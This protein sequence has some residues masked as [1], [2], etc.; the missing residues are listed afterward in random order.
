MAFI[1]IL[2]PVVLA[3][4]MFGVGTSLELSDFKEIVARPKLVALGLSLQMLFLPAV[5]FLVCLLLPVSN[6]WKL[7]IIIL[8]LCPGGATSNF[9]SYLLELKTAL[10]IS[11]TAINSLLILVTIPVGVNLGAE[12]FMHTSASFSLSVTETSLNVLLIVL[13][14]V[15]LGLIFHRQFPVL[16]EH[17]KQPV[18]VV[19][20]LLLAAVFAIKFFGGEESGGSQISWADIAVLAPVMLGF[21]LFTM[22][23]SYWTANRIVK[24]SAYDAI[25]IGIEVGLQNTTLALLVATVMIGDE[26]MAEPTLVYAMFSFFTTLG[27]GYLAKWSADKHAAS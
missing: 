23:M 21:H 16:A 10:S 24:E 6:T 14:P 11:L 3:L 13:L 12:V 8:S 18:K 20:T 7:G 19:T 4:T 22:F 17:F 5:A 15:S 27:F 26:Q 9:I 25:T 1:D 2:I